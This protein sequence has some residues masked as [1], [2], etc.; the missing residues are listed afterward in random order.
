MQ[1]SVARIATQ[2]SREVQTLI[3]PIASSS[4]LNAT[5]LQQTRSLHTSRPAQEFHFDTHHFVQRLER[6]GL[7]RA[8]AE[9]IMTAMAEVIDE[10]IR[11]ITSNMVTKAEQ[12]KVCIPTLL[13]SARSLLMMSTNMVF[14]LLPGMLQPIA[15]I[16]PESRLRP[17]QVRAA[18]HGE[19]RPVVDESGE[20]PPCDGSREAQAALARG[21]YAD[22][23]WCAP[24]S[25]PRKRSVNLQSTPSCSF[26]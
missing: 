1:P 14:C 6:E 2:A 16:Y 12:E 22:T 20:R 24:R 4:R 11:N 3:T 23:G 13:A 26:L 18:A 19:E 21:D 25:K 7:N 5:I 10:S 17:A 9:G 15:P 8:Q